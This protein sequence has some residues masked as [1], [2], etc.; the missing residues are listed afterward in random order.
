MRAPKAGALSGCATPRHEVH[1]SFY[2]THQHCCY[3]GPSCLSRALR[4]GSKNLSETAKSRVSL[5]RAHSY[6]DFRVR[7]DGL[8]PKATYYYTIDSADARG[9]SDGA[10]SSVNT[11]LI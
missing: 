2:S 3:S 1:Y 8:K 7:L 5:N 9:A 4:Y 6:T 11:F 10:T